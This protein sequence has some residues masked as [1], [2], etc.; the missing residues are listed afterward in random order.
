MHRA[1]PAFRAGNSDAARTFLKIGVYAGPCYVVT[2]NGI[3]D[4][5]GQ[6]VNIAARLQGASGPGEV[7]LDGLFADE[8]E[9]SGW[10]SNFK[11]SEHFEAQPQ[12]PAPAPSASPASSPIASQP[13][14]RRFGRSQSS[15]AP[16]TASMFSPDCARLVR[17][18]PAG[19]SVRTDRAKQSERKFALVFELPTRTRE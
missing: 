19:D 5:F 17:S 8:A 14:A 13:N 3:L 15:I 7:V 10:L 6:T 9:R 16:P 18:T 2:A 12:G 11:I 1:F 4:Y